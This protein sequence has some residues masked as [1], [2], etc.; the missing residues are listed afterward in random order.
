MNM[1][2]T[3]SYKIIQKNLIS[4]NA[5]LE[6]DYVLFEMRKFDDMD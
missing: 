6:H 1:I 3:N 5:S 4:Q 2:L